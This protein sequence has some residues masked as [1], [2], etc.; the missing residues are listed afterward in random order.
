[1][2]MVMKEKKGSRTAPVVN[3]WWAHTVI[4]RPAIATVAAIRVL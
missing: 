4:D 2:S 3:R 1:M